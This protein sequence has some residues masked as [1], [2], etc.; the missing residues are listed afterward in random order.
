MKYCTNCIMPETRPDQYLNEDGVCNACLSY[1][2]NK[3]INWVDRKK[4]VK[5]IIDEVS[6]NNKD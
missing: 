3:K 1:K 4:K 2:Y 5:K 6:H